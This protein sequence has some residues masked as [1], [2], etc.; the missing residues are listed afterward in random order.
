MAVF[1]Y[2]R[3]GS[4]LPKHADERGQADT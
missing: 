1:Q 2:L 4:A 3:S